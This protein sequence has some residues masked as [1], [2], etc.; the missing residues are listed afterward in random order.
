MDT[1][2]W[3]QLWSWMRDNPHAWI[4]TTEA[5]YDDQLGCVPPAAHLGGAFLVG[6]V[7]HKNNKGEDVYAAFR[8]HRGNFYARYLTM[9]EFNDMADEIS[10]DGY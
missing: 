7:H 9:R 10:Q 4:P 8:N 1:Y 2:E 6:E 5:M 3:D